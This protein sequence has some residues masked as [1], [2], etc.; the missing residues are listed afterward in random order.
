MKAVYVFLRP[1]HVK[2]TRLSSVRKKARNG[3]VK[4]RTMWLLF[5]AFIACHATFCGSGAIPDIVPSHSTHVRPQTHCQG[6]LVRR[7]S[8]LMLLMT[9]PGNSRDLAKL[10]PESVYGNFS[11]ALSA[12][13]VSINEAV[14]HICLCLI[15]SPACFLRERS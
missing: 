12:Y 8:M 14:K 15:K 4:G 1:K 5:P 11:F 2:C 7:P 10:Q 6:E 3:K 9:C 13:I